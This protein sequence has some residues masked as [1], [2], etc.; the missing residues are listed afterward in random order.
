MCL[1][2]PKVTL[3][4]EKLVG[5][6]GSPD[7]LESTIRIIQI[8][9]ILRLT[10]PTNP[11]KLTNPENLVDPENPENLEN[12]ENP[13]NQIPKMYPQYS[14]AFHFPK[15]TGISLVRISSCSFASMRLRG[16]IGV[17]TPSIMAKNL[18]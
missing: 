14:D 10:G 12:S 11:E 9:W 15:M 16:S 8:L 13:E 6:F 5:S 7:S 1:T 18:L 2:L 4:D 17:P 3:F